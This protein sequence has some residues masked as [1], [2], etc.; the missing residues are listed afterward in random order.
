MILGNKLIQ[1]LAPYEILLDEGFYG[2]PIILEPSLT[3]SSWAS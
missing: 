2:K 3:R 1:D